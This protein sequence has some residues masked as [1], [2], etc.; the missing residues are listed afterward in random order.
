MLNGDWF[1]REKGNKVDKCVNPPQYAPQE[2]VDNNRLNWW[3]RRLS[4]RLVLTQDRGETRLKRT[5][6]LAKFLRLNRLN[7]VHF[8]SHQDPYQALT[9]TEITPDQAFL[10]AAL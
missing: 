4:Y 3:Q 5:A 1:L 7:P 2:F 10:D 9:Q 6:L 8:A